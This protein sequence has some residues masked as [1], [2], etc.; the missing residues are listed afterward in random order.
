MVVEEPA[1]RGRSLQI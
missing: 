1:S